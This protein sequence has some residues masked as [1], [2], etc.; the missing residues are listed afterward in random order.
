MDNLPMDI[1]RHIYGFGAEHREALRAVHHQF[2]HMFDAYIWFAENYDEGD[3]TGGCQSLVTWE[4]KFE[5]K[6]NDAWDTVL[7]RINITEGGFYLIASNL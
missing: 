3:G 4:E 5:M 1:V 6:F 2:Q 7:Y